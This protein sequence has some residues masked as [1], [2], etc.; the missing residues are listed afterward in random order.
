MRFQELMPDSLHW[1]GITK[2]DDL[3]SMSDMK[4]NAIVGSGIQVL[5][6][7]AIPDELIPADAHVEIDAKM[8]AGYYVPEDKRATVTEDLV[9]MTKGRSLDDDM[10]AGPMDGV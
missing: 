4:Y 7:V 10:L 3:V 5:N 8:Y 6:R 1:L 2:I 9:K